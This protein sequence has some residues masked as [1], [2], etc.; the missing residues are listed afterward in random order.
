MDEVRSVAMSM[1]RSAGFAEVTVEQIA[2]RAGV[3]ASTV[4][5][6]FGT[7]EALVLS[8]DRPTRLVAEFAAIDDA[9]LDVGRRFVAAARSVFDGDGALLDQ[10]DLIAANDGLA[11]AFEHQWMSMRRPLAEHLAH[12][13]GAKSS[14]GQDLYLASGLLGTLIG[15]LDRWQATGGTKSL[16]KQLAKAVSA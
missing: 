13:R 11:V 8:G 2:A 3:S 1:L 15:V 4:Y 9:E 6:Y 16:T 5:R 7:K 14:G 12:H 10:L